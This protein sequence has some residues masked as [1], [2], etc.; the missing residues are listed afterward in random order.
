MNATNIN[1]TTGHVFT[2]APNLFGIITMHRP[3]MLCRFDDAESNEEACLSFSMKF[4][5]NFKP[6]NR[7]MEQIARHMMKQKDTLVLTENN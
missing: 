3:Y 2:I 4:A 5:G 7:H 1:M 6:A